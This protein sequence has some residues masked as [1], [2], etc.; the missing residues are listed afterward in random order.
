[1]Q[2]WSLSVAQSLRVKDP[3]TGSH[4]QQL[5]ETSLTI[6]VGHESPLFVMTSKGIRI[7]CSVVH[8]TTGLK[9]TPVRALQ[10]DCSLHHWKEGREQKRPLELNGAHPFLQMV[11]YKEQENEFSDIRAVTDDIVRE[12]VKGVPIIVH[13][14]GDRERSEEDGILLLKLGIYDGAPDT[15]PAIVCPERPSAE[16]TAEV[17]KPIHVV[18]A[19]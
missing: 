4:R 9:K 12:G 11:G 16:V 13:C 3:Q 19:F 6:L 18:C 14:C 17:W 1:M 8:N 2:L 10:A 15:F 7:S 5:Q